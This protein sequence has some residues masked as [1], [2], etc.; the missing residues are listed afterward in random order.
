VVHAAGAGDNGLIGTM[1][2]ER[3]SG[4]LA[5]KADAAWYLHE[6]TRELPLAFFTLI[7]SAGGLILA[8]GQANYAAANTFLDALA[9][10]RHTQGLPATSLAYGLWLGT[11]LGQYIS[12]TDVKRMQRQGLPPLEPGEA[13]ALFDAALASGQA[14]TVPL[15]VDR[16]A[17]NTRTDDIA[18]LL[19]PT[20]T[21]R[22][23]AGT[24]AVEA[25]LIWPRIAQAPRAEQVAQLRDLVQ[26]RAAAILGH[27][28]PTAV[29]VERGFLEQGFDSLS[30]MELRNALARDTALKLPPMV[31]FDSDTPARLATLLLDE[32]AVQ[33]PSA[34]MSAAA[35]EAE[36][37]RPQA[38]GETLRDLFH[39]A[40][41]GGHA[42]KGFDLLRAAA[43]VRPSF[44]DAAELEQVPTA[45]RLA[46]GPEGP[47]LIFINTP[48]ATGGAYQHARLV[49][50]LTG[51]RRASALPILGFDAGERLPATPEAAV[52]GLARTVLETAGGEPFVLVGY[53]SGGTL[54]YA[55]AGYLEQVYG[56]RPHGVVLLDTYTVHDG[57]S[58]GVPMDAL[59]QGLF[60]KESA[61]GRFDTTRL[62]AM[63][64]WVELVPELPQQPL[65]APVLFVQCTQSFVPDGDNPSPELTTGRAEPWEP[66]HTLRPVPANHFTLI[67]ERA[68]LTARALEEWLTAQALDTTETLAVSPTAHTQQ[69][70]K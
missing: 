45:T 27:S 61:F 1:T 5:P 66:T 60:D 30:A 53:S 10:H 52:Q 67:E 40:V 46:D 28:D 31:V 62:S 33:A 47:H 44:A 43:A 12:E 24:K 37:R 16:A 23:T 34:D 8:A 55:T 65:Q 41:F 64:R 13:L 51:R 42:D 50:R 68:D 22:R 11:G 63:G 2:A 20:T 49:S 3:L 4:V 38:E 26:K 32:Y 29:D 7:S 25:E 17:L 18:A 48:M 70:V 35:P 58:E 57:A 19:R 21:H 9:Q 6:L 14:A 54:A 69:E 56:I 15:H 59:A 36:V 39:G